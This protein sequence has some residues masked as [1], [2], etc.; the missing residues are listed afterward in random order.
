MSASTLWHESLGSG[1]PV[2]LLHAGVADSGM[3]DDQ[4]EAFSAKHRVIRFDAQ[5]FGRS[6]AAQRPSTRADDVRLLLESL[7]IDR[8]HL[9]GASMGG[10]AAIDFAVMYPHMVASLVPVGA[11]LGGYVAPDRKMVEWLDKQE[12][13]QNKALERGDLDTATEIDLESWLAGPFRR[14][15]DLDPRLRDRLRPMARHAL[16]RQA[17]RAPTPQIEPLAVRRVDDIRAPT[18]VIV[19]DKD[20]PVIV[21]IADELSWRIPGARKWTFPNTAHMVNMERPAE[22]NRIVLEFL[23]LHP[24]S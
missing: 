2:V 6:P 5:G 15:D 11:G 14:L 16:A 9:I 10:G 13:R 8:A 4:I 7:G 20:V 19:G 24:I 22:F 3:W 12:E 17:E 21:E 23:A 1:D 18:L